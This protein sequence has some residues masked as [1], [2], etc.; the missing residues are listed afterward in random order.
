MSRRFNVDFTL[1]PTCNADNRS[2]TCVSL[3]RIDFPCQNT[4]F[5]SIWVDLVSNVIYDSEIN[6]LRI[7]KIDSIYQTE[8][9]HL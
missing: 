6:E 9:E 3:R 8:E 2:T 1:N 7:L 5:V 4:D